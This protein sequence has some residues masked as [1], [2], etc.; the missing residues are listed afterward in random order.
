MNVNLLTEKKLAAN[1]LRNQPSGAGSS[2]DKFKKVDHDTL[3]RESDLNEIRIIL[4]AISGQEEYEIKN[5]V[6]F[7]NRLSNVMSELNKLSPEHQNI[8]GINLNK[9]SSMAK[10]GN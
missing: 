6:E 10:P 1:E 4:Q 8:Q 2:T 5:D 3:V 9:K 7:E